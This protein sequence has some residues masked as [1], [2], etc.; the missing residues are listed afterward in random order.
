M[1]CPKKISSEVKIEKNSQYKDDFQIHH[2]WQRHI[3][4]HDAAPHPH[5]NYTILF[6]VIPNKNVFISVI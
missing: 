6:P 5:R 2:W 1:S 4:W 3:R